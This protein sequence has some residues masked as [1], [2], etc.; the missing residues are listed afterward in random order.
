M[1][2]YEILRLI[3]FVGICLKPR[4]LRSLNGCV[5][6]VCVCVCVC[7]VCVCVCVYMRAL[8]D[9]CIRCFS[10]LRGRLGACSACGK[11]PPSCPTLSQSL[12][13]PPPLP[14]PSNCQPQSTT[15]RTG[16]AD[17]TLRRGSGGM[18]RAE[19]RGSGGTSC[20]QR[21]NVGGL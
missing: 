21:A 10:C 1:R 13:P 2:M 15:T 19:R 3:S 7:V 12:T 18:V 20:L 5:V 4:R 14:L 17:M 16:Q 6:C 11:L 9:A 8:A